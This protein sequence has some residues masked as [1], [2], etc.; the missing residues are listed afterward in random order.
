MR[1]SLLMHT[2]N[3]VQFILIFIR[4]L[5]M[6]YR[7]SRF[8]VVQSGIIMDDIVVAHD[9]MLQDA[10]P[11]RDA[12]ASFYQNTLGYLRNDYSI[13]CEESGDNETVVYSIPFGADTD[14]LESQPVALR[15]HVNHLF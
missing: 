6:S 3:H 11:A 8:I 2:F 7:S 15:C 4:E 1:N 10:W 9:G 12:V 5:A 13:R 14:E